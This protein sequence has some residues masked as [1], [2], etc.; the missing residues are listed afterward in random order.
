MGLLALGWSRLSCP[1]RRVCTLGAGDV[2]V[3]LGGQV[4]VLGGV[5]LDGLLAGEGDVGER[6]A[7]R[8][9]VPRPGGGGDVL[10]DP[11]TAGRV[12][13]GCSSCRAGAPP[14]PHGI[15]PRTPNGRLPAGRRPSG[16]FARLRRR[17]RRPPSA[18]CRSARRSCGP[19]TAA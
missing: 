13:H 12:G 16:G 17:P 10:L 6:V 9:V 18:R 19:T 1:A 8:T 4:V 7:G 2:A 5:P 15:T 3:G 14:V 11:V